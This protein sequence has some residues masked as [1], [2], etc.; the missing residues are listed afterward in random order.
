MGKKL[1]FLKIKNK[2]LSSLEQ[3]ICCLIAN[4]NEDKNT[5]K[6]T[7]LYGFSLEIDFE[8]AFFTSLKI[9]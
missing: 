9:L 2:A 8:R 3:R 6:E 4:F 1:I 5:K 7:I